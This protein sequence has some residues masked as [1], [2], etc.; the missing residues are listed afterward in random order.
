MDQGFAAACLISTRRPQ[1]RA[2][3][4]QDVASSTRSEAQAGNQRRAGVH[5]G[6]TKQATQLS[7]GKAGMEDLKNQMGALRTDVMEAGPLY[8][9]YIGIMEKKMETTIL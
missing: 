1:I 4:V 9:G 2:R 8:R 3:F 5:G 7:L 6:F